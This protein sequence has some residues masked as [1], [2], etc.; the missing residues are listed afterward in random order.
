MTGIQGLAPY[1]M[2]VPSGL[3]NMFEA[4][5]GPAPRPMHTNP[6][7]KRNVSVFNMPEAYLGQNLFLR[8][9]IEDFMFTANQTW[10]TERIL[11]WFVTDQ[12]HVQW[13]QWETM[14]HFMGQTPHQATSRRISQR[15]NVRRASLLRRGIM[16]EFE[17]DFVKTAL[18]QTS[19]LKGLGQ[20]ARSI[21]ETANV[22]V[23]RALV[24]SHRYTQQYVR[25]NGI[26]GQNDLKGYLERDRDRFALVQKD[27]Q[28]LEKWDA[29]VN[30]EQYLWRGQSNAFIMGEE[31]AIYTTFVGPERILYKNAGQL[32]PDRINNASIGQF[33]AVANTQGA[34]DRI[35]PLHLVRNQPVF[36]ARSFNVDTIGKEELLT[37][38]RAIGEYNTMIDE[39][40]KP[41]KYTS[42]SRSISVFDEDHDDFDCVTLEGA[43]ENC[44]IWDNSDLGK[45]RKELTLIKDSNSQYKNFLNVDN[46][47]GRTDV[48]E[49]IAQIDPVFLSGRSSLKAGATLKKALQGDDSPARIL[50][51]AKGSA[52]SEVDIEDIIVRLGGVVRVAAVV[53]GEIRENIDSDIERANAALFKSLMAV[54]PNEHRATINAIVQDESK[55]VEQRAFG[56]RDH[57]QDLAKQQHSWFHFKNAESVT[58]WFDKRFS[59]WRAHSEKIQSSVSTPKGSSGGEKWIPLSDPLPEGYRYKHSATEAY[60]R[61]YTPPRDG[62]IR[63]AL[64]ITSFLDAHLAKLSAQAESSSRSSGGSVHARMGRRV[65]AFAS[66]GQMDFGEERSAAMRDRQFFRQLPGRPDFSDIYF[67]LNEHINEINKYVATNDEKAWALIYLSLPFHK[68]MMLRLVDSD[69]IVPFNFILARPQ[70]TYRTRTIIK[71]QTDG[72]SG[73][74]FFGHSDMQIGH[75]T[76]RKIGIAH[77]TAYMAA[78]VTEPRNVYV[79]HDV[80]LDSYM[81]GLG[82]QWWTPESYKTFTKSAT[83]FPSASMMAFIIP[84]EETRIPIV[85]DISGRFYTQMRAGLVDQKTGSELA[86]TTADMYNQLYQFYNPI[87]GARNMD[88]PDHNRGRKHVNRI[89]WR[90]CQYNR[91]EITGKYDKYRANQGH[92]GDAVYP[93]C[94]KVRNGKYGFLDPTRVLKST[95][96]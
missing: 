73:N 88:D 46:K 43:I 34:L 5:L 13:Q 90:G 15:R 11:P 54:V 2:G 48:I 80:Q 35:E 72:G 93:G 84:Y 42:R 74:V 57:M 96:N 31:V 4:F 89:V 63:S 44:G 16:M 77:Y 61:T 3:D 19:F 47:G 78:V 37:R 41:D 18:G 92:H 82:M 40:T 62:Q 52:L 39:C 12:I 1:N 38:V 95:G 67:P 45:V 25:D 65:G 14:P 55:T 91:N 27:Q 85:F 23:I 26:I 36:I 79:Q 9:T 69:V 64:D 22:E 50:G 76:A 83:L 20:I 81:G 29:E 70:A 51:F 86:Y 56:I 24:Q 7:E 28:G 58:E 68:Q 59:A 66:I 6:Y 10:Y 21:Q 94:G 71:C 53:E 60:K 8:D 30:K 75:D 49:Y 87:S 32:G 17:H 33:Q